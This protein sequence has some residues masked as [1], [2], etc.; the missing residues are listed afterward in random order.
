MSMRL[1][2]LLTLNSKTVVSTVDA[3]KTIKKSALSK[4]DYSAM[5]KYAR[6]FGLVL[7]NPIQDK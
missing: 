3:A 1:N 4:L 2:T 5:G 7:V 6:L